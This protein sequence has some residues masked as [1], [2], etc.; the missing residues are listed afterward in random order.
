M[1]RKYV[2]HE[3]SVA[4]WLRGAV[5]RVTPSLARARRQA[6]LSPTEFATVWVVVLTGFVAPAAA[7]PVG[8]VNTVLCRVHVGD[9]LTLALA[10]VSM[11]HL[12]KGT[13]LAVLA[14]DKLGSGSA[15]R[16]RH[17]RLTME[18]ALLTSAGAFFPPIFVGVLEAVGVHVLGCLTLW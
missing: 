3:R 8:F 2:A 18:G 16:R 5:G 15:E 7:S 4:Q 9:L 13:Y 14:A 11:F 10:A 12:V 6:E 17:G 1:I